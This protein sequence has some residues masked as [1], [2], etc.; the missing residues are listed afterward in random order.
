MLVKMFQCNHCGEYFINLSYLSQHKT[1]VH[2]TAEVTEDDEVSYIKKEHVNSES[3]KPTVKIQWNNKRTIPPDD[4][5]DAK[6][7]SFLK[8]KRYSC[9]QCEYNFRTL[10]SLS[11]HKNNKHMC[12]EYEYPSN[13]SDPQISC[14]SQ[15]GH[16]FSNLSLLSNHKNEQ[17]MKLRIIEE[18][19]NEGK[20]LITGKEIEQAKTPRET[21]T[22]LQDSKFD[23]I[24]ENG[25]EIENEH[26]LTD[27]KPQT[28]CCSKCD[29]DFS[30]LKLLSEHKNKYHVKFGKEQKSEIKK[31][32]ECNKIFSNPQ[33]LQD[34]IV[35]YH[36]KAYPHICDL[37]GRGFTI[38]NMGRLQEHRQ[39]CGV[40]KLKEIQQWDCTECGKT[41]AALHRFK[42]HIIFHTKAKK[43]PCSDCG[44]VYADK[45]NLK[46]HV[47][48]LHPSSAHQFEKEKKYSCDLC[49]QK[50]VKKIEVEEHK[51]K[52]H[53]HS[54]FELCGYCGKGFF[55]KD[56]ERTMNVHKKKCFLE[57]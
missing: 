33:N 42:R 54:Y 4:D 22:E 44:R 37:C 7:S 1:A 28:F 23:I 3:M 50:F 40:K 14:C 29:A 48:L 11:A 12:K 26:V 34:H 35:N 41:F 9:S 27:K 51:V 24:S 19:E 38:H 13:N 45:N 49:E 52:D 18:R 46:N 47:L 20:R 15:C 17:H 43:F 6:S 8:M 10:E 39:I 56:Y 36:T 30:T 32:E 16:N 25:E 5:I 21:D 31:C 57:C 53:G 55:K 2:Y